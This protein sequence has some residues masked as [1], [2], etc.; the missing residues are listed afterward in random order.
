MFN[1]SIIT[2]FIALV[3][4]STKAALIT[5]NWQ[6]TISSSNT[7]A[8]YE[9]GDII[10]WSVTFDDTSLLATYFHDGAD[11]IAHTSDDYVDFVS[12]YRCP[13]SPGCGRYSLMADA[14]FDLSGVFSGVE[15]YLVNN[16]LTLR[17][18]RSQ[19]YSHRSAYSNGGQIM[20]F[21]EEAIGFEAALFSSGSAFGNFSVQTSSATGIGNIFANFNGI[22]FLGTQ[23]NA[24]IPAPEPAAIALFA[25]GLVG[26]GYRRFKKQSKLDC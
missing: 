12:D 7:P 5:E 1:K 20:N 22:T 9:V 21:S 19:H 16:N 4:L 8:L 10:Q 17:D 13:S 14:T 2:V 15:N 25:L 23:G 11:D 6:A 26:V 24:P 18:I 3:S